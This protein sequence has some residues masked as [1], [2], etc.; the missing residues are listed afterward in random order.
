MPDP[1][2]M[3]LDIVGF[4]KTLTVPLVCN[5]IQWKNLLSF[6]LQFFWA[7]NQE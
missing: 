6:F 5:G 4:T 3:L 7:S 2:V 1:V